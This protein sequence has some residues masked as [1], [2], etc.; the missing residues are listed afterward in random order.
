VLERFN[1]FIYDTKSSVLGIVGF[2]ST[3]ATMATI[4]L[5]IYVVG[6][7]ATA[8]NMTFIEKVMDVVFQ[9]FAITYFV[10]VIYSF[11]R[12]KFIK[13]TIYE[14]I[15]MVF[16]LITAI[17][18]ALFSQDILHTLT[19]YFSHI[20][21]ES[22]REI[23]QIIITISMLY[24][25]GQKFVK[26]SSYVHLLTINPAWTFILSFILL[27]SLG[28][29]L[30]L[31]PEMSTHAGGANL[32]DAFFTS[33]SAS[34]VTGLIVV[35]TAT[36][37]T[38]KG[39]YVLLF[40]MQFGG[41]GIVS[42]AAF[43]TSFM[44]HGLGIKHQV[45]MQEFL[46]SES[47]SSA[48]NMLRKVILITLLIESLAATLLFFTWGSQV[49]FTH[50]G[51]KI[52]YSIFH[53]VSAFCNAGFSLFTDGL[54]QN[55][56]RESYLF[57]VV[58]ACAI[59]I[60]SIGFSTI[61]DV[62]SPKKL[63]ERIQKPWKDWELGSKIS[64]YTS[65]VLILIGMLLFFSIEYNNTLGELTFFEKMIASFFQS[66]TTRT[67]GFNT[68]DFGE[69]LQPTLIFMILLMFIGASS[70]S[71]GGGIKTSTFL[72]ITVSAIA[73]IRGKKNVD[74]GKR[75]ISNDLLFKAFSIFAFAAFYNLMMIFVL[76]IVEPNIDIIRIVFEQVSAFATVGLSTGI[77]AE[78]SL[79]GKIIII[80]S[81]FFGR[82]GTLT[83]ALA[84][85]TRV[86]S[87]NYKYPNAHLLIG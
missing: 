1:Q 21:A 22:F 78:L 2:I 42:F 12:I 75:H 16:I 85:S 56:I 4:G 67:A 23:Y 13:E 11:E 30:L 8:E 86:E 84:L 34:C 65:A 52:F 27:I 19:G 18:H 37:W 55:I 41:I 72:L 39:H 71:T 24:I 43:F 5:I 15:L 45:A 64:I 54:Y 10:K 81:M 83:L 73:T 46:D 76:S 77:T 60:G 58:I 62:L 87:T 80:F 59:I 35:D 47:L 26:A 28:T 40:M 25:V 50:L 63:R 51:Q 38:M 32:L 14:A 36:Y 53:G 82:I 44:R 49:E 9:V 79:V 57:Q 29:G 20:S 31:L 33:V 7:P 3:I 17:G 61:Q 74:L 48:K 69:F 68:L 6:F 66:V 70:G